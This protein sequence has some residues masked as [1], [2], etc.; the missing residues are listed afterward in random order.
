MIPTRGKNV[1]H[2][3]LFIPGMTTS[4]GDGKLWI[5]NLLNAT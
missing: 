5:Q 3:G 1:G 2:T 4:L